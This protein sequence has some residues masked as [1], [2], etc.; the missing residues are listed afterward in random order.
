[1]QILEGIYDLNIYHSSVIDPDAT[2][3]SP[4]Y[5]SVYPIGLKNGKRETMAHTV[6][7]A[8]I[9]V[10]TADH[11][12]LVSLL[13]GDYDTWWDSDAEDIPAWLRKQVLAAVA[14]STETE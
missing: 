10:G 2:D 9:T 6:S 3:E 8:Q 1:M 12:S 4:F 14:A 11:A 5:V 13:D 7:L